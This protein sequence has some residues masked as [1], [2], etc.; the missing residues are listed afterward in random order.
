MNTHTREMFNRDDKVSL[1]K[2]SSSR[3]QRLGDNGAV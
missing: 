2:D 3:I 1:I